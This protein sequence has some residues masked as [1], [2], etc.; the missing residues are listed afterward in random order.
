MM[1]PTATLARRPPDQVARV[2]LFLIAE[3]AVDLGH[4]G[5]SLRLD[6]RRAAGDDDARAGPLAA[7][8]ADRLARLAHGLRRHRAGVDHHGIVEAGGAASRRITSNSKVL[9]RQPKVTTS[10]LIGAARRG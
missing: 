1:S 9:S 2:E 8:A 7:D 10:T 6:L 3:H 5:E 4:G